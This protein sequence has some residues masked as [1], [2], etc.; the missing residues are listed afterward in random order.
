MLPSSLLCL[1]CPSTPALVYRLVCLTSLPTTYWRILRASLQYHPGCALT[2][3]RRRRRIR[4]LVWVWR[5]CCIL[6]VIIWTE[7]ER[8]CAVSVF[9]LLTSV[10][11]VCCIADL[12]WYYPFC[13]LRSIF[14]SLL[15]MKNA[16]PQEGAP[17]CISTTYY[18]IYKHNT[19]MIRR[20]GISET[21]TFLI[22]LFCSSLF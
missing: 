10:S 3:W 15:D 4:T 9:M 12:S 17:T 2:A 14:S 1:L 16:R 21:N 5:G 11:C 22:I 7:H 8:W 19:T 13:A 20:G 6:F 18:N